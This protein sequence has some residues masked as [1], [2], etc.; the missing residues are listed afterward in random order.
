[1]RKNIRILLLIGFTLFCLT[2]GALFAQGGKI[3]FVNSQEVLYGTIEGKEGLADL[4]RFMAQQRNG[5]ETRN[6]ELARLQQDLQTKGPTLNADAAA[7][8]Q[9]DIEQKQI[10]L[11]RY[12]EDAEAEFNQKQAAMLQGISEKVQQIIE[13]YAQ[14]NSFLV[15]FMRDQTQAFVSPNLD[16]TQEIIR[17]YNEKHPG[18]GTAAA[19]PSTTP[20]PTPA[21]R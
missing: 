13:E 12:Q 16:I 10:E 15:I 19:A 21:P 7:R 5:F 9:R 14:Q 20:S 1:M 17:I 2:G 6:T 18:K 3:G 11:R 4:D 8:L